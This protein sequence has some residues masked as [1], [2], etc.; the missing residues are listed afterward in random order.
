MLIDREPRTESLAPSFLAELTEF[1]A[2]YHAQNVLLADYWAALRQFYADAF[3]TTAGREA[4]VRFLG[5]LR[6]PQ[7]ESEG[8]CRSVLL[9]KLAAHP[10]FSMETVQAICQAYLGAEAAARYFPQNRLVQVKYPPE[11]SP[12]ENVVSALR[13]MI[14]AALL[15]WVRENYFAF[16]DLDALAWTWAQLDNQK[17][18]FADLPNLRT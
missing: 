10:P 6:L 2:L 3:P 5:F 11:E 9:G 1:A 18:T 7:P 8:E 15:L 13:E 17:L 12:T 16:N 4:L 14:P